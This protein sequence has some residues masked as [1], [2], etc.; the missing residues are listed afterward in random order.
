MADDQPDTYFQTFRSE[1]EKGNI[2][3]PVV[4][5]PT[6]CE[7]Y[8][9]WTD[10]TDCFP[11]TTR[12]QYDNVFIPMLR[13]K[14]CYRVKP[15]G[16][17]YHPGIVLDVI[18]GD[19]LS[20][21][22]K[23][24]KS[25]GSRNAKTGHR[26]PVAA[27]A[28]EVSIQSGGGGGGGPS[29]T[30]PAPVIPNGRTLAS[31]LT[32]DV[33]VLE[34]SGAIP[35]SS[36]G[37]S[38]A[39]S[40]A[41]S[42]SSQQATHTLSDN[43]AAQ[44]DSEDDEDDDHGD[45][46]Y[47]DEDKEDDQDETDGGGDIDD[48]EKVLEGVSATLEEAFSRIRKQVAKTSLEATRLEALQKQQQA[49]GVAENAAES[50]AALVEELVQATEQVPPTTPILS[51]Q[52]VKDDEDNDVKEV[53]DVKEEEE[54]KSDPTDDDERPSYSQE[55]AEP[56]TRDLISTT[57][58]ECR[59]VLTAMVE[60]Y[61]KLRRY[62]VPRNG[63]LQVSDLVAHRVKDIL[64]SHY[65]WTL[66]SYSR[67]FCF[68]PNVEIASASSEAAD[69]TTATTATTAA[70]ATTSSPP[71]DDAGLHSDTRFQFYYIC[72]C[73]DIPGFEGRWYPHWNIRDCEHQ[74]KRTSAETLSQQQLADIIP[75]VG[76]YVVGVL[77]MLKYGVYID[78]ILQ[79]PAQTSPESQQRLSLAIKYFES[80][81]V[82]TCEKYMAEMM[83]KDGG[84]SALCL[85]GLKPIAPL[86]EE[87]LKT[88]EHKVVKHHWE[89]Y[90][91][92]NPYR[93]S[94]GDVRWIC[95]AHWYDLAPKREWIVARTFSANPASTKSEY[96]TSQG[97]FVAEVTNLQRA[98]DYFLLAGRL[99]RT[100]IFRV[101]LN[102]DMSIGDECHIADAIGTIS[103]AA[104]FITVRQSNAVVKSG[105][106]LVG[107]CLRLTMAALRNPHL[108]AFKLTQQRTV[109]KGKDYPIYNERRH[110]LMTGMS[111]DSLA[112]WTRPKKGG[113]VKAT[114][115]V[116]DIDRA[117][118]SIRLF[119]KGLHHFSELCLTVESVWKSVT[120]KFAE[121]GS[122]K[123]GCDVEDTEFK[124]GDV[125]S[126]FERREFCDEIHYRGVGMADSLFLRSRCLTDIRLEFS[127]AQDRIKLRDILK[128]NKNLKELHLEN[129]TKD[130]PS[131]IY[132]TYK[133][134]LANHSSIVSFDICHRHLNRS[135]S[136]FSWRNP[137][138]PAKM[139][140]RITCF[141]GDKVQ[142]LF[143]KYA[144]IIDTLWVDQLQANEAA[145]LEK[146]MRPKKGTPILR[147]LCMND[148]HLMEPSVLDDLKKIILRTNIE[149]V[150]VV[151]SIHRTRTAP[152]NEV[153]A[154]GHDGR[155]VR[156]SKNKTGGGG[157]NKN[158]TPG[159]GEYLDEDE[160][161]NATVWVDFLLAI[162]SR[163]TRLSVR[164]NGILFHLLEDRMDESLEFSRLEDLIFQ[165]EWELSL[166]G[167]PWLEKFLR[168]KKDSTT[169]GKI[170]S[171]HVSAV[172]IQPDE[173]ECLLANLDFAQM[174]KFQVEQE[175]PLSPALL[176]PITDAIPSGKSEMN[177]FMVNDD[178]SLDG[179]AVLEYEEKV[180]A[181]TCEQSI[182][183][184]I[185]GYTI[186]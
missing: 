65:T 59:P 20:S 80:K 51:L 181:K 70:A 19:N 35:L 110:I 146:A 185:N 42:T 95:Q 138:D 105:S 84:V 160:T 68:L 136:T 17:R 152:D 69:D 75:L 92:L 144:L 41:L 6:L 128:L 5:H 61:Q 14:R 134:P 76:E 162:R 118:K 107:G 120:I 74:H 140:L 73:G 149:Q 86:D 1:R 101:T 151:G 28:G 112:M 123:L 143:Q 82:F 21:R 12:I 56:A 109:N 141:E 64:N 184:M 66:S 4:R 24:V 26:A 67:F 13:D 38:A 179:Y 57:I 52:A 104:L 115:K 122:R 139:R 169:M 33:A 81:G 180:R 130:D 79:V 159:V 125:A 156:Y 154:P 47:N 165:G 164:T 58:A 103:G 111:P 113:K 158:D 96:L 25:S 167:Y 34:G 18:Y 99:T 39:G 55:L 93:T 90:D 85:N 170:K 78:D 15:H 119:A 129:S 2:R 48:A 121:P 145:A 46:D 30:H 176:G 100:C 116:M 62:R 77:E 89:E 133:A 148:P 71:L 178:R 157:G 7:L 106:G 132:E 131:Q 172:T 183:V 32:H 31:F 155:S 11:G 174:T 126:Y 168:A 83:S 166:F 72:D 37:S 9:I 147:T 117:A 171:F 60:S 124:N 153:D 127:L 53:K 97:A 88:F 108:E 98:L 137:N 16:I 94:E 142:S 175:N 8:V 49:E 186:S 29:D 173:W 3:I 161:E 23:R 135:P 44:D 163:L 27:G 40:P 45:D 36:L 10:I 54:E 182:V 63:P 177:I 87:T 102:W 22:S 43:L 114:L 50:T 91:E 150:D